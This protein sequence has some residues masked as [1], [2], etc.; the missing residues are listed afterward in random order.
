LERGLD[1]KGW[2]EGLVKLEGFLKTDGGDFEGGG[3]DL[4][5]VVA[6]DF[7][8]EDGLGLTDISDVI[9]AAGANQVVLEPAVRALDFSFGLWGKGVDDLD[10]AVV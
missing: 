8:I 3:V 10:A 9:A 7:A 6:M 1:A 4:A 5:V 2:E